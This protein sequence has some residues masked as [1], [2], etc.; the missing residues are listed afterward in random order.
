[1]SIWV[2]YQESKQS[3]KY[4]VVFQSLKYEQASEGEDTNLDLDI[5]NEEQWEQLNAEEKFAEVSK[6]VDYECAKLN[7]GSMDAFAIKENTDGR[8]AYYDT[9][10]EAVYFNIAYLNNSCSLSEAIH[11]VA[12]ECYHRY[13]GKVV[14][15]LN[16]LESADMNYEALEYFQDA[17]ALRDASNNYYVDNLSYETYTENELEVRAEKYADTETET[18]KKE[19]GL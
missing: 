3:D 10:A 9:E 5:V 7:V 16:Y 18:L 4:L 1:M 12:H 14:E 6:L 15:S 2:N 17:I 13:T 8:L 19:L 11:L